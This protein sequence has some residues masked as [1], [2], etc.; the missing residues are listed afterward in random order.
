MWGNTHI[1]SKLDFIF[2]I[3]L[4]FIFL[5]E[6][7]AWIKINQEKM[8]RISSLSCMFIVTNSEQKN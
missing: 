8:K 3:L 4:F 2:I 7:R 5:M 1:C 6:Y